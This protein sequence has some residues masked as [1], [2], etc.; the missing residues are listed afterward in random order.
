MSR[1]ASGVRPRERIALEREARAVTVSSETRPMFVAASR[2][3]SSDGDSTDPPPSSLES[4][5]G[6]RN[7]SLAVAVYCFSV[8]AE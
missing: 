7:S 8:L 4:K 5:P 2:A 1:I 3:G 6:S